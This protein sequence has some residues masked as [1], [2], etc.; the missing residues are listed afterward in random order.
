MQ[1]PE[2]EEEDG[3]I[4]TRRR[5]LSI[6]NENRRLINYHSN[7]NNDNQNRKGKAVQRHDSIII[8]TDKSSQL[9]LSPESP[10]GNKFSI[11]APTQHAFEVYTLSPEITSIHQPISNHLPY[12]NISNDNN[13][14][15]K[16]R[17]LYINRNE[18]ASSLPTKVLAKNLYTQIDQ[19]LEES[20]RLQQLLIWCIQRKTNEYQAKGIEFSR[21]EQGNIKDESIVRNQVC[22]IQNY[23]M[24]QLLEGNIDTSWNTRKIS[25]NLQCMV[26]SKKNT[27]NQNKIAKHQLLIDSLK[28]E[29]EKWQL[30]VDKVYEEHASAKDSSH[31]YINNVNC[32]NFLNSLGLESKSLLKLC[33]NSII[34][35]NSMENKY[36]DD[37]MELISIQLP[38]LLMSKS[39]DITELRLELSKAFYN[40]Q[41]YDDSIEKLLKSLLTKIKEKQ[42]LSIRKY[43]TQSDDNNI[44]EQRKKVR[45]LYYDHAD[46][47]RTDSLEFLKLISSLPK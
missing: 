46:E 36:N 18:I 28:Q 33:Y 39:L 43:I 44:N 42:Q 20:L 37:Y 3:F 29:S 7:L 11:T 1:S 2:V 25:T 34:E 41:K 30:E 14:Y 38:K 9:T 16:E 19:N 21:S 17:S 5:P 45:K 4:F 26:T 24:E 27:R 13:K 23:I 8:N 40:Q 31:I 22:K 15:F 47:N 10:H 32:D 12:L 6:N 35:S